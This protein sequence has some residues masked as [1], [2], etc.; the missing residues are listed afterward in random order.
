MVKRSAK[1]FDPCISAFIL[2]FIF[3]SFISAAR[4]HGDERWYRHDWVAWVAWVAGGRGAE[5]VEVTV[6]F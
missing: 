5:T 4:E 3:S 2:A 1:V 6:M